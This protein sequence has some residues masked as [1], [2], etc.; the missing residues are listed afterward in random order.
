M[1]C[2]DTVSTGRQA[3]EP[4]ALDLSDRFVIKRVN[5][6][7]NYSLP[8]DSKGSNNIPGRRR[9]LLSFWVGTGCQGNEGAADAVLS[10]S[11]VPCLIWIGDLR[12]ERQ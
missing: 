3:E 4:Q 5:A 2:T 8:A 11:S 6:R 12:F 9:R 7:H 10:F 1:D